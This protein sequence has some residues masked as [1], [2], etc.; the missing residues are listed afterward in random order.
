MTKEKI[1]L[2]KDIDK[3]KELLKELSE[4]RKLQKKK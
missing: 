2:E 4:L 3:Q 1:K